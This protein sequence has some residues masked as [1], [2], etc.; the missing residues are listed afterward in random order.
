MLVI[1]IMIGLVIGSP[2]VLLMQ[3]RECFPL[4]NAGNWIVSIACLA[5]GFA[6]AWFMSA[7]DTK[8]S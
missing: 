7:I 4:A 8:Q 5:I 6:V 3:N 2:V 1:A